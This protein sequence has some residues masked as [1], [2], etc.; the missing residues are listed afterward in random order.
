MLDGRLVY[1]L[2]I[3]SSS[4]AWGVGVGQVRFCGP[5]LSAASI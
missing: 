4:P 1:G 3:S 2:S 5:M